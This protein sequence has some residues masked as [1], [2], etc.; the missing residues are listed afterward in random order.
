MSSTPFLGLRFDSGMQVVTRCP[1]RAQ[2][3][4]FCSNLKAPLLERRLTVV[5]DHRFPRVGDPMLTLPGS[6]SGAAESPLGE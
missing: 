2:K 1:G 4:H 3:P 6:G 5:S